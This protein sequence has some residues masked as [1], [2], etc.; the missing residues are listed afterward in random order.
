MFEETLRVITLNTW[1]C[2]GDYNQRLLLMIAG[3]RALSPD[4]VLL[5]EDFCRLDTDQSTSTTL[6]KHLNLN[7]E[8]APARKKKRLVNGIDVI[9]TSGLAILSRKLPTRSMIMDLPTDD[10]DG[11]RIAL[12]AT[13]PILHGS[14]NLCNVHLSHL[15]N[16]DDLR[17]RQLGDIVH[18]LSLYEK[19]DQFLLGGD[20]NCDA[21]S[22]P[23]SWLIT[24]VSAPMRE[25]NCDWTTTLNQSTCINIGANL[26]HLFF[27]SGN[28]SLRP[29]AITYTR[30]MDTL[31]AQK[32]IFPSD[33]AGLMLDISFA[34][35]V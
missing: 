2:S 26:D 17:Q 7:C 20:F 12:F 23:L 35:G 14:L 30:V 25:P 11:E 21:T 1:K 3:L 18:K 33:H 6:A 24:Q 4:I 13:V 31:D 8:A 9:S 15:E 16:R 22:D 28:S 34:H 27:G 10:A 19:T 29:R 32:G 5:Q